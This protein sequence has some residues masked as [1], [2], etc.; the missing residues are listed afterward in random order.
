MWGRNYPN[1][2]ATRFSCKGS[3]RNRN[4]KII[5]FSKR[6]FSNN[7]IAMAV[8]LFGVQLFLITVAGFF[9]SVGMISDPVV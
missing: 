1:D 4:D 2:R 3:L 5:R 7:I 8:T 6:R 9:C